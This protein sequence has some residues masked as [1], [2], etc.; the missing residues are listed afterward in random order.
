MSLSPRHAF[1]LIEILI[2]LIVVTIIFSMGAGVIMTSLARARLATAADAISKVHDEARRR[3]LTGKPTI[4]QAQQLYG[5][6]IEPALNGQP[7]RVVLLHGATANDVLEV[8]V[9]GN[10]SLDRPVLA[11]NIPRSVD[12]EAG[13]NGNP[14]AQLQTTLVWWYAWGS[15][16]PLASVTS[17]RPIGIGTPAQPASPKVVLKT[18]FDDNHVVAL[19]RPAIPASP[20]C[21]EL[22]FRQG[23]QRMKASIYPL[24]PVSKES[25]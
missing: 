20:V 13:F 3:A 11:V 23:K 5:V 6:A 8:D 24:G 12:I 17:S 16:V 2:V 4:A 14:A 9:D 21:S 25:F 22:I 1:T 19:P 18:S 10:G 7:A 15:G